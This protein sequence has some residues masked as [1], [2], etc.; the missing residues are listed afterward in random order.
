MA[1]LLLKY[2]Y[3]CLKVNV[4]KNLKQRST[5]WQ[6]TPAV[7][8]R[9]GGAAGKMIHLTPSPLTSLLLMCG[10]FHRE[11]IYISSPFPRA[12]T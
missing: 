1:N 7:Y 4:E 5:V 6:K 3:L 9:K 8:S 2:V 12:P 10:T 11:L